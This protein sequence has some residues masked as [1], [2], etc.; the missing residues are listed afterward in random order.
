MNAND[1]GSNIRH[2]RLLSKMPIGFVP[3]WR[4]LLSDLEEK[5]RGRLRPATEPP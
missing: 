1:D 3:I 5:Q 2:S 4:K